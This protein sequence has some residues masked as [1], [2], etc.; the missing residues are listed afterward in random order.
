MGFNKVYKSLQEIFPQ[1]D[2]RVL[3][4]VAIEHSKDADAA[5]EAVL[6]EIIPF[7]TERSRPSTPTTGSISVGEP[8]EGLVGTSKTADV[9]SV[10]TKGSAEVQNDHNPNGANEQSSHSHDAD[11]GPSKPCYD[12]YHGH[13]EE[14]SST[15]ELVLPEKI[16]DNSI[17]MNIDVNSPAEAVE[18]IDKDEKDTLQIEVSGD[19][20]RNVLMP[21][22]KYPENSINVSSDSTVEPASVTAHDLTTSPLDS[23]IQLV[24]LP[25]VHGNDLEES[26]VSR[27]NDI[28]SK[29]EATS[30]IIGTEEESTLNASMSQSSQ[31]RI[32]DILEEFIADARNSKKTLLSSVQSVI[33]L[34]REVELKEQA[35]EQAKAEAAMGGSDI[36]VKVEELKQM[37]QRGKEANDK[38]AGNVYGEKA[39]LATELR[40]LHSHVLCLSVERNKSLAV[41]DEMR[42]TL[43]ERLAL[44]EDAIKSAEQEKIEKEKAAMKTLAEQELI[45][46]KLMQEAKILKQQAE[47]NAKL[48]EFL[49]DRG[50]I[51]DMLQG[52]IA[53]ICEDVR[54]LKEK[55]DE[56]VPFSQSLSSSQTSRILAS[57]TS[58]KGSISEQQVGLVAGGANSLETQKKSS[59]DEPAGN[60]R[61]TFLD[62]GWEIFDNRETYA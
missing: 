27:A 22:D 31:I 9:P 8:S 2:A 44:A 18:L 32:I 50:R 39:I 46:E 21:A 37:L 4:A 35:A 49:V 15:A 16:L 40:E 20:E 7:F 45:M 12:T 55:F 38:H 57:S 34:M 59:E 42:Q 5:V 36:L 30:N 33:S 13:H 6:V 54:L 24:V 19:P 17:E 29:M 61:A 62:D 43:E 51:V 60:D 23:S 47:D 28:D 10:N 56:H 41:L 14:G 1:I 48:E 58:S 52:E 3:R 25:D 26:D 53:V 11:D